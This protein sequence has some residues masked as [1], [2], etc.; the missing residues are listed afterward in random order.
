MKFRG[1]SLLWQVGVEVSIIRP[2]P[3]TTNIKQKWWKTVW[4]KTIFQT[5]QGSVC[6]D[7]IAEAL[8]HR[9]LHIMDNCL[10]KDFMTHFSWKTSIGG[11]L[12]KWECAT[13]S[14]SCGAAD[15]KSGAHNWHRGGSQV[16]WPAECI[17]DKP[18]IRIANPSE[19]CFH[20]RSVLLH[21]WSKS[22]CGIMM[23]YLAYT[24]MLL[25]SSFINWNLRD[26]R[27][28]DLRSEA[29]WPE[30]KLWRMYLLD[31]HR[32]WFNFILLC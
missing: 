16:T 26:K 31:D 3:T 10:S 27:Y 5:A 29:L 13:H 24:I 18:N 28:M 2:I 20:W 32:E 12:G 15:Y 17:Q 19:N 23:G 22:D 8:L 25:L 1:R 30:G 11:K 7:G 9:N 14:V 21:S 6:R 4:I